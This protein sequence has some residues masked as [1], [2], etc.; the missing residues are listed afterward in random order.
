M[1]RPPAP[2]PAAATTGRLVAVLRSPT[3]RALGRAVGRC[4]LGCAAGLLLPDRV[5]RD[6][7]T[8]L[9]QHPEP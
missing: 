3:T 9:C 7:G 1:T 6:R 2:S 5:A 4:L 8:D